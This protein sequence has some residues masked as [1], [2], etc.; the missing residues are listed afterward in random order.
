ML[1]IIESRR[2]FPLAAFNLPA[3]RF[4]PW[5]KALD[6]ARLSRFVAILLFVLISCTSF[7]VTLFGSKVSFVLFLLKFSGSF[8]SSHVPRVVCILLSILFGTSPA[9]WCWVSGTCWTVLS[10]G[11]GLLDDRVHAHVAVL[12]EEL[13]YFPPLGHVHSTLVLGLW[14]LHLMAA[15]AF[16]E[17][18]FLI[19]RI[20]TKSLLMWL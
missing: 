13:L 7:G 8:M 16:M 4:I 19:I 6:S 11:H 20:L 9:R 18:L 12:G 1:F 15:F 14:Y 10:L 3:R 5:R 17:G 2:Q